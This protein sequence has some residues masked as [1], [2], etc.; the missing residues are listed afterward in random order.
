MTLKLQHPS[1]WPARLQPASVPRF[2]ALRSLSPRSLSPRS[3]SLALAAALVVALLPML[4]PQKAEARHGLRPLVTVHLKKGDRFTLRDADFLRRSKGERPPKS[5]RP[6]NTPVG[7]IPGNTPGVGG[8][9]GPG[10]DPGPKW[11]R[12]RDPRQP[13]HGSSGKPRSV[14]E[15]LG[16]GL[17]EHEFTLV[18]R[19]DINRVEEGITYV[20][21]TFKNGE[22]RVDV[23]MLWTAVSG[24]ERPGNEGEFYFFEAEEILYLEFPPY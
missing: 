23:P 10:D 6:P 21:V 16:S 1:S 13:T 9:G 11:P 7:P 2:T 5:S 3:L 17:N 19:M 14:G 12:K 15:F 18:R 4:L 24:W 22:A 20:D 8:F